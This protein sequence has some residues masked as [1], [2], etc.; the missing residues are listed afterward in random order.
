MTYSAVYSKQQEKKNVKAVN[1]ND[2]WSCERMPQHDKKKKS[3][4]GL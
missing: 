1:A 3:F 4:E 2:L